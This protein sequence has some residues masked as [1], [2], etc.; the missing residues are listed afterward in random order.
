MIDYEFSIS[1]YLGKC[2]VVG[3]ALSKN[4]M[5]QLSNIMADQWKIMEDIIEVYPICM[6]N[7]LVVNMSFFNDSVDSI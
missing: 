3:N 4:P 7:S 2:Y 6:L 1:Y 5:G